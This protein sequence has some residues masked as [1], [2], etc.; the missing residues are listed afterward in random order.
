MIYRAKLND[1]NQEILAGHNHKK[2]YP[3]IRCKNDFVQG[4]TCIRV[5]KIQNRK[6]PFHFVIEQKPHC[7]TNNTF[8]PNINSKSSRHQMKHFH[9]RKSCF[10]NYFS[11][12]TKAK[13]NKT[14]HNIRKQIHARKFLTPRKAITFIESSNVITKNQ[15]LI[16]TSKLV[17]SYKPSFSWEEN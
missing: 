13:L 12:N 8:I 7:H 5:T 9:S 10:I 11:T 4:K 2:F 3:D 14:M 16:N 17:S 6:W 15:M 1:C